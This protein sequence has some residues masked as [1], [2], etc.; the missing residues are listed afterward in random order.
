[1]RQKFQWLLFGCAAPLLV[2]QMVPAPAA[3]T[4]PPVIAAHSLRDQQTLPPEASRVLERACMNCH[5]NETKWP[6]YSRV[7]P[8]SWLVAKDV[9]K[10]RRAMNFSDWS[11][12]QGRK[13]ETAIAVWQAA[14]LDLQKKRMPTEPYLLLHPEARISPQEAKDFCAW[15]Q[16]ETA[17]LLLLKKQRQAHPGT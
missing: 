4:N 6:W 11:T 17:R 2:L 14:C 15:T 12:R 1:M 10:A 5:S 3:R 8:M 16:Q 9:E 7:A 13:P